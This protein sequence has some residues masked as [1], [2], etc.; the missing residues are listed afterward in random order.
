VVPY[1][2]GVQSTGLLVLAALRRIDFPV[3][4]FANVGHD[5]EDPATL[6]YLER[7][8]KPYAVELV[9][10]HRTRRDGRTETL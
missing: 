8:A 7:V 9:E 10:L 1:G 2:G 3:F 5:A 6:D 4:L